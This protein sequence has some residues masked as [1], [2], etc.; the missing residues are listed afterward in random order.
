MPRNYVK[1]DHKYPETRVNKAMEKIR[2]KELSIREASARYAIE[3]TFLFRKIHNIN[4]GVQGRKPAL[5]SED[6]KYLADNL[7]VCVFMTLRQKLKY[8]IH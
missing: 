5:S 3:Q 4:Q 8:C 6:E 1:K 2:K 7:K